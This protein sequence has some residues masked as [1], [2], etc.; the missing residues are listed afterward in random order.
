[1]N[2]KQVRSIRNLLLLGI[3]FILSGCQDDKN[4]KHFEGANVVFDYS[5]KEWRVSSKDKAGN[6][7]VLALS[8]Q[9]K[10]LKISLAAFRNDLLG[11]EDFYNYISGS[12]STEPANTED[13][14]GIII[15]T[16]TY[17]IDEGE[18]EAEN[19]FYNARLYHYPD[20]WYIAVVAEYKNEAEMKVADKLLKTLKYSDKKEIGEI[21][22][23]AVDELP[24]IELLEDFLYYSQSGE[25]AFSQDQE[26][27]V[28]DKSF[29]QRE[30]FDYLYE[31]EIMG[32]DRV[33]HKVM[34]PEVADHDGR[35]L[36]Y[37]KHGVRISI[38]AGR[39]DPNR[40]LEY[41]YKQQEDDL[42]YGEVVLLERVENEFIYQIIQ[43]SNLNDQQEIVL[44]TK[45]YF[46]K[47]LADN[48][49]LELR[50]ELDPQE[51]DGDTNNILAEVLKAYEADMTPYGV[52]PEDLTVGGALV[53]TEAAD[54]QYNGIEE[55]VLPADNF[56]L[57]GIAKLQ[58]DEYTADI[59]V[60]RGRN[61][62]H[63]GRSVSFDLYGVKGEVELI[64][65]HQE[66]ML[67]EYAVRELE[68][69]YQFVKESDDLAE[70]L[71]EVE[72]SLGDAASSA[73]ASFQE[74]QSDQ[75]QTIS[76]IYHIIM[77]RDLGAG[78]LE[79][80]RMEMKPDD[81]SQHTIILLQEY[82]QLM[83]LDLTPFLTALEEGAE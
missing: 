70:G 54:Y 53:D 66:L 82:G 74:Y 31:T 80:V 21:L 30:G 43:L 63:W 75:G 41:L 50:V 25:Q 23:P 42:K 1:M 45:L 20:G 71:T 78:Y 72:S 68:Y 38:K 61:T 33:I 62:N 3:M 59:Y 29:Q 35:E 16:F 57:M 6:F 58:E 48:Q 55:R 47:L 5:E 18:K 28:M 11:A 56:Q 67:D 19:V 64:K 22:E 44:Y 77:C 79:L 65:N 12:Y 15:D 7:D 26:V 60:P 36:S 51:F 17:Q 83:G 52:N 14:N 76:S 27:V 37:D 4:Y 8:H 40:I 39:Y 34:F 73:I 46:I 10:E 32:Y 13:K 9:K 81:F 49:I 24:S 2:R 69:I